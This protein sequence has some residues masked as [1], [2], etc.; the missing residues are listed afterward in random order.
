MVRSVY[1]HC[2]LPISIKIRIRESYETTLS[3][4]K[5]LDEAG[6]SMLTVHG[7]T[8]DQK[9]VNT[10]IADWTQICNLKKCLQIPLIANGNI[11]VHFD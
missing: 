1:E 4:V 3:F 5:M 7:R 9:G 11:Q 6:A 8:R 2:K 10:G